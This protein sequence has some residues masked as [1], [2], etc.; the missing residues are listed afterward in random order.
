MW[1][2][3]GEWIIRN[4][5]IL[6]IFL[7]SLTG[8]MAWFASQVQLS[9]DFARAIPV[10]NPKYKE[11]LLFKE[12]FGEDGNLMTV[13]FIKND[14]FTLSS[15]NELVTLHNDLKKTEGVEDVISVVSA[16]N[17]LKND[18]TE[19][20]VPTPIFPSSITSQ[21]QLDSLKNVF[22]SLP[23]YRG[24]MYNPQSNAWLV[25][26]KVNKNV[27]NSKLRDKVVPLIAERALAFGKA[28][29][30]EVHLSGLPLIRSNLAIRIANEMKY[31]LLGSLLLSAIILVL[32]FRS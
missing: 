1:K 16:I 2:K 8:V 20:L 5:L 26:V 9:Y 6:L 24:L 11:Y 32:F 21:E 27:L 4:R 19:K 22:L 30:M 17:L 15:F 31:F 3:L 18:S 23:F 12:K 25:G 13:G 10:D 29:N 7:F 14:L 28:N